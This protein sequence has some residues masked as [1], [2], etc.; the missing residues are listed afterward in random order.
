MHLPTPAKRVVLGT[1]VAVAALWAISPSSLTTDAEE[2]LAQR[3]VTVQ[4]TPEVLG[5]AIEGVVVRITSDSATQAGLLIDQGDGPEL[6]TVDL[7]Y[8]ARIDDNIAIY[9]VSATTTR[10]SFIGCSIEQNT[11]VLAAAQAPGTVECS[12]DFTSQGD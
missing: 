3:G 4:A 8:T 5:A 11:T 2:E 7:P 10:R 12:H 9:T 6:T 1:I